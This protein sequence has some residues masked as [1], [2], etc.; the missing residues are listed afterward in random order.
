MIKKFLISTLI[1]GSLSAPAFADAAKD[2]QTA[3][4][5]VVDV[6]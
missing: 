5:Q 2:S 6:L 1:A 3:K 4:R